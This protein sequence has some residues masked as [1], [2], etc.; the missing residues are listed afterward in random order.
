VLPE[1]NVGSFRK[2]IA[3]HE[4]SAE[5]AEDFRIGRRQNRGGTEEF[6]GFLMAAL[7]GLDAREKNKGFLS[8]WLKGSCLAKSVVS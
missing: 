6:N 2:A 5:F 1:K 7:K 4:G 8:P 3:F